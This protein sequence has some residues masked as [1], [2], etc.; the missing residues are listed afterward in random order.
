MHPWPGNVRELRNAAD[1]LV[2]GLPGGGTGVPA[3]SNNGTGNGNGSEARSLDEQVAVFERHLI[4]QALRAASGRTAAASD[5]LR[6]PK[7]TLYDK[8][9]RLGVNLEA[10][11]STAASD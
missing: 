5:L 7:K 9:K 2:L 10:F 6:V 4:E 1:R 8:I 11:R 3:V